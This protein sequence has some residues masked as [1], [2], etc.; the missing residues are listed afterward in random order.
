MLPAYGVTLYEDYILKRKYM[1]EP[2]G[3]ETIF[4][5]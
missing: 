4:T 5:I 2:H 3:I 1:L